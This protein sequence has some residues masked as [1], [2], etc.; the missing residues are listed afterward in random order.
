METS[1]PVFG[2]CCL[3]LAVDSDGVSEDTVSIDADALVD[4]EAGVLALV[5]AEVEA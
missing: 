3:D 2:N 5:D 1:V 4:S